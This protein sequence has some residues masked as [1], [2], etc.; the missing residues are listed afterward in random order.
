MDSETWVKTVPAA[1]ARREAAGLTW[2][3]AAPGGARVARV[4]GTQDGLVLERVR[5][6]TPT[7][8]SARAFGAALARTHAAGAEGWGSPPPGTGG[9]G[10]LG[11]AVLPT[12]RRCPERWGDFYAGYRL[13]PYL[14]Q[15]RDAG[16]LDAAATR[17][18][19][20]CA[21]RIAD[22][23]LDH[24][25]PALVAGSATGV[26]RVHGDL[27]SGNVLWASPDGEAV[28]IDPAAHGGHAETDLAMLHLFG[29]PHL[30]EV[31]R[32]YREVSPPADGWRERL[33][34]HQLHPLAV[35]TVLFGA[36]YAGQLLAAARRVG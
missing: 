5:A 35:H 14:R 27:W 13:L 31:V 33:P 30:E 26:A 21:G 36:G 6:G 20:R 34:L 10:T 22:G 2:L 17:L 7:A 16:I 24:D 25:Q 3:A 9:D 11:A 23:G 29:L 8:A 28:L 32:G 12:P 4:L 19:E 18:L 1:E 15:A